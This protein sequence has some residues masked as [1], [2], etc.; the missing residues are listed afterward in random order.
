TAIRNGVEGAPYEQMIAKTKSVE[1][2][3]ARMEADLTELRENEKN[4]ERQSNRL[5]EALNEPGSKKSEREAMQ[6]QLNAIET[7]LAE[8]RSEITSKQSAF[9]QSEVAIAQSYADAAFFKK[10]NDDSTIGLT[11]SELINLNSAERDALEASIAALELRVSQLEINDPKML[12][13]IGDQANSPQSA[14]ELPVN[15]SNITNESSE[16]INATSATT[17]TSDAQQTAAPVEKPWSAE[18]TELRSTLEARLTIIDNRPELAPARAM[19]LRSALS[20]TRERI[21]ALEARLL[22]GTISTGERTTLQNL[23][24][25]EPMLA[26]DFASAE[27]ASPEVSSE[28]VREMC[29]SVDADYSNTLVAIE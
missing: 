8:V 13:L 1:K 23:K 18:A 4:L 14:T 25:Y 20:E 7:E 17:S 10:V 29:K 11:S 6:T 15:V 24:T 22:D 19:L 21:D 3:R 28:D 5:K 2:K 9:N 26:Q 12:A 27:A 16:T